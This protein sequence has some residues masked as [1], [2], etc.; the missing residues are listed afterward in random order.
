M[1]KHIY[2]YLCSKRGTNIAQDKPQS[3]RKKMKK[4]LIAALLML[5]MLSQAQSLRVKSDNVKVKFVADMQGT[6]GTISGFMAK[7]NFN[8]DDL[9]ASTIQGSVDANTLST[10]NDK[11]DEHLKSADFFEVA[12][13]PTM[14]FTSGKIEKKGDGYVM[15]G[16]LKIKDVERDEVITFTF[17]DKIF[18]ASTTIQAANYGIMEKKGAKKTN[19]TISFS[20]PVE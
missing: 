7:I 13:Y 16:K 19:V 14:N 3:N 10:A 8:M 4:I 6:E 1:F 9:A 20:I 5:P 17:A 2:S 15:T 11:R 18:T 12:K